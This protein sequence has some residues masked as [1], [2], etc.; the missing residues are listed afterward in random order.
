MSILLNDNL[1]ISAAKAVDSRYGPYAST[2]VALAAIPAFQR[3]QGLVIGVVQTGTLT[4]YWFKDG[5]LDGS[6]LLKGRP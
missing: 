3:Y 1:N 6:L 4:E 2:A 5:I